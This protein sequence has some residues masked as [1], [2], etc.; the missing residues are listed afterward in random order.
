ATSSWWTWRIV[1]LC[2]LWLVYACLRCWARYLQIGLSRLIEEDLRND[3]FRHL[4]RLPAKFFDSARIGDLVSRTTSDVELLRFMAGPTLFFGLQTLLT[5]PAALYFLGSISLLLVV[6]V[7]CL[8]GVIGLGMFVAFPR[9]AKASRVV[10]DAQADIASKAQEDFAGIRVIHGFARERDEVE[11]FGQL[12]TNCESAQVEMARARGLLHASFVVGGQVAPLAIVIIGMAGGMTMSA[13]FEAFLYMQMLIWPLMMTGWLLQSWH[14][15]RAAADRIDEIFDVEPEDDSA[16]P[17]AELDEFPSIEARNLFF[18]YSD[19]KRA[20]DGVTFFA[21]GREVLGIVGPIGSGKSTLV[22][23][24]TRLYEPPP[25]TLFVGGVDV[26][27]VRR[28]QLRS[29]FAIATQEPFL[30]SDTLENNVRFGLTRDEVIEIDEDAARAAKT[31]A[32]DS[33]LVDALDDASL[34]IEAEVFPRGLQQLVGE[35][36]VS[37]SGGQKQRA[38]LARALLADREILVLDDTLSAVD[39]S[40]E[41]RIL[42]RLRRRARKQTTIVI[43]HRLDAVRHA[44]R[45]LVLDEGNLVAQGTHDELLA[46]GGWYAETWDAQQRE[47]L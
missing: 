24:L 27:T 2:G 15:A 21:A 12:A 28:D 35:R 8:M 41:Q 1:T 38:S 20:L 44:D 46:R 4:Q 10:Q 47:Q 3:M 32:P 14:R 16:L 30:F 29:R 26:T 45:I 7:I 19:G 42:E 43:A 22:G 25:G 6:T 23:L 5:F 34:S 17:I 40:T 9:L 36:G 13:L 39:A 33:A 11:S 37:L 31:A 18:E